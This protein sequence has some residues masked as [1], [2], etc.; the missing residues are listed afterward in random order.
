MVY[1]WLHTLPLDWGTF[2]V[3]LAS[4]EWSNI[5]S[6]LLHDQARCAWDERV[7]SFPF[8]TQGSVKKIPFSLQYMLLSQK[9]TVADPRLWGACRVQ[10]KGVPMVEGSSKIAL[11]AALST[12]VWILNAIIRYNDGLTPHPW[13]IW[14][15]LND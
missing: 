14:S 3:L 11:V 12:C 1:Q 7:I 5:K 15:H 8:Y 13:D 2:D 9:G 4:D 6:L 10:L